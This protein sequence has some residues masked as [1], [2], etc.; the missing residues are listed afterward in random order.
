MCVN[1]TY[2]LVLRSVDKITGTNSN[3][4][5]LINWERLLPPQYQEFNVK[6]TMMTNLFEFDALLDPVSIES[7][8][9][10]G[11]VS[12]QDTCNIDSLVHHSRIMTPL[13][14]LTENTWYESLNKDLVYS[15]QR[16]TNNIINIRNY[17]FETTSTNSRTNT[18]FSSDN[19]GELNYVIYFEFTPII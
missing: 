11:K 15:I 14:V 5:Y 6:I 13:N 19:N 8:I 9:F 18:I 16:P 17:S 12:L 4:D 1:K 7:R 2:T 10:M 3:A